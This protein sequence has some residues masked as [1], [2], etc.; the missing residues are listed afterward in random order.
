MTNVES[1]FP[2]DFCRELF[3]APK[4]AL[5]TGLLRMPMFVERKF[6]EFVF[7]H[8]G[9]PALLYEPFALVRVAA[10]DCANKSCVANIVEVCFS[11]E[12]AVSCFEPF[13]ELF[14]G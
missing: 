5:D 3:I 4:T 7:L 13:L 12:A 11:K 9:Q 8:A 10:R 1:A 14:L 2:V 6:N